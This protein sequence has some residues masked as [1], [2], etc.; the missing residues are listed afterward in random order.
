MPPRISWRPW[1]AETKTIVKTT[2]THH[3]IDRWA[4]KGRVPTTDGEALEGSLRVG[5]GVVV[6]VVLRRV[7]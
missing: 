1:I 3:R 6:M 4:P 7:V 5:S 2:G